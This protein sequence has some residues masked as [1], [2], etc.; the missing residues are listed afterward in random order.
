MATGTIQFTNDYPC[1]GD[2]A[3]IEHLGPS[4]HSNSDC[5]YE[6]GTATQGGKVGFNMEGP[7]PKRSQPKPE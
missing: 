3:M 4:H 1:G 7:H 5:C 6:I 2:E